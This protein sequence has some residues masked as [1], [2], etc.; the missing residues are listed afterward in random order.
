MTRAAIEF[1]DQSLLIQSE[2]EARHYEPGYARLTEEGVV[3]GE[4]ARAVA[5]REP[6]HTYNQYWCHL[7]LT[8]LANR[9]RHARHHADIAFAQLRSLWRQAEC[10][11]SLVLLAPGSFTHAQ[12]SLLLGLVNALPAETDAVLDSA[13]AA[14]LDIEE[15]TLFVDLHMHEAVL[16]VCS[17]EGGTLHIADQEVF[18]GSGVNQIYNSVARHISNH[19]IESYRFDPLHAS[20][21]EQTIYDN[22]PH[23]LTRLGWEPDVS[24][25]IESEKGE[26]PCILRKDAIRQL[27]GERLAGLRAFIA[28]WSGCRLVLAHQSGLLAGVM[29]EFTEARVSRRSASTRRALA[30]C[31]EI[32]EQ[33]AELRRIRELKRGVLEGGSE[34]LNGEP[35]A[36]HLMWGEQALPLDRPLS[37]GIVLSS[38]SHGRN[39]HVMR[40]ADVPLRPLAVSPTKQAKRLP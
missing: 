13:L 9:H 20:E 17:V 23:W 5:W 19:L 24:I 40:L 14:C 6:Q 34:A 4:E 38:A 39:S 1:N 18:P 27:V 22:L 35:L 15:D 2:D 26:L 30:H 7:N 31:A 37:C 21:T 33:Y 32:Q 8:P 25:K 29:D 28:E 11:E 16:T 10:P 36:T 12:L 3:S